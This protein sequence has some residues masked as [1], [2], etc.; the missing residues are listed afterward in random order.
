LLSRKWP[1]V[2]QRRVTGPKPAKFCLLSSS[3]PSQDSSPAYNQAVIEVA[4]E[5]NDA[6]LQYLQQSYEQKDWAIMVLACE[7][8][9]DPLRNTAPFRE[10]L[11]KLDFPL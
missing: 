6:A 10:L 7:P 11:T 8:R 1:I 9:L 3:A 2:W 4:L 5:A